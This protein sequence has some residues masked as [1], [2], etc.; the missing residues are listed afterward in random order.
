MADTSDFT[1]ALPHDA[2]AEKAILGAMLIDN[3][4][5]GLVFSE[6]NSDDFYRDS[7][8]LIAAAIE[9]LINSGNRADVVTVGGKLNNNKELN[10]IGGYEYLSSILDGVPENINVEEYV[11]VVKDRSVLRKLMMLSLEVVKSGSEP[12]AETKEIISRLQEDLI[13]IA[14]A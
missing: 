14:V 6:I 12:R 13:K 11:R 3:G 8:R 4:V 7:H 2:F 5:A 1:K 10:F 9:K